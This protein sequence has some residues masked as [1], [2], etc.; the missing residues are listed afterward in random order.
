MMANGAPIRLCWLP[1]LLDVM[2]TETDWNPGGTWRPM[3]GRRAAVPPGHVPGQ[4]VLLP[5]EHRLRAFPAAAGRTLHEAGA[6][7]RDVP[8]LLQPQ[9][10]ARPLLHASRSLQPRPAAVPEVRAA[11]PARGGSRLGAGYPGP[12]QR[13]AGLRRTVRRP[14]PGRCSTTAASGGRRRSSWRR[15]RQRRRAS[16]SRAGR[17]RGPAGG[18]RWCWNP[19]TWR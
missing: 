13:P 3:S 12:Q 5:D 15:T 19:K 4:A 9:R 8:R 2:G 14:L 16:C 17:S 1:P 11:V 7:L 10:F 18:P 6:G